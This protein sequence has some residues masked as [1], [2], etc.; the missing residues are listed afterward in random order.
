M[1]KLFHLNCEQHDYL[2]IACTFEYQVILSM[3]SGEQLLG[4]CITTSAHNGEEFL[5]FRCAGELRRIALLE[6][7]SMSVQ[8]PKA[9]FDRVVF[10]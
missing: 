1:A 2:E 10:H 3:R 9:L 6:L 5:L 4:R 7:S 8:T